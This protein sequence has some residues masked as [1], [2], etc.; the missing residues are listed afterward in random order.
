[1]S[2]YYKTYT[3]DDGKTIDAS[4]KQ[5]ELAE[6]A[7]NRCYDQRIMTEKEYMKALYPIEHTEYLLDGAILQC[8][9][10][11]PDLV[12]WRGITY[13][14]E[15]PEEE[16]KLKVTENES[17]EC[18]QKYHATV[19]DCQKGINIMPFA[20]NCSIEPHSDEEWNSLNKD[21]S[22]MKKGTCRALMNLNYRWDNLPAEVPYFKFKD[23]RIKVEISGI[24]MT[25]MLFCKHGGIITPVTSGQVEE[26]ISFVKPILI[27][28]KTINPQGIPLYNGQTLNYQYE[29]VSFEGYETAQY[30]KIVPSREPAEAGS[31]YA[32]IH[33]MAVGK[34]NLAEGF[35]EECHG[36]FT[37]NGIVC[38]T[39]DN[40]IEIA[41]RWGI[42]TADGE[43]W[44]STLAGKY[45]DIVLSDGTVLACIMGDSKGNEAGSD[46]K[47]IV[48][49]DGS[50]IEFLTL[51]APNDSSINVNKE[52]IFH[53]CDMVGAYVYSDLRLCD[54]NQYTYY[55]SD[56][57]Q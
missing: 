34:T 21:S 43:A 15:A 14:V 33:P 16:I 9:K 25:S 7:I 41:C 13:D 17:A 35:R 36:S 3:R 42:S 37:S 40:R 5:D 22:C 51:S 38:S 39:A 29:F 4:E 47:G 26:E 27:E 31:S 44:A 2:E 54:G 12:K 49:T 28:N 53:G 8:D 1:M 10:T 52:D 55:F 57:I 48:H 23:D 6:E 32:N 11:T 56:S 46:N 20:C 18:C 45:I 50:I 30:D 19:A 24:T